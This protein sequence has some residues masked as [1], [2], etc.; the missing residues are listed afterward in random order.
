MLKFCLIA[1]NK[2]KFWF[3]CI[4]GFGYFFVGGS[5]LGFLIA[6][7]KMYYWIFLLFFSFF[8]S[9]YALSA[10][11]MKLSKEKDFSKGHNKEG[12]K[13]RILTIIKKEN[14]QSIYCHTSSLHCLNGFLPE[15][16]YSGRLKFEESLS[17]DTTLNPCPRDRFLA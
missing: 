6:T 5:G 2:I 1:L 9:K 15:T 8:F 13:S 3:C 12:L 10:G 7:T 14:E 11:L 16:I 4:F 17:G